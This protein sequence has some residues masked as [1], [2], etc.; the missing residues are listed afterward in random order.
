MEGSGS[1]IPESDGRMQGQRSQDEAAGG[2]LVVTAE[3]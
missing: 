1:C 2:L 3:D